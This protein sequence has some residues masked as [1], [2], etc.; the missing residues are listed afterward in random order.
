M[1]RPRRER[2]EERPRLELELILVEP[3]ILELLPPEDQGS[4]LQS[5]EA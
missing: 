3:N 1:A 2:V 5:S 4:A